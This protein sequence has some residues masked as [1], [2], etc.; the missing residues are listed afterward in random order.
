MAVARNKEERAANMREILQ[1]RTPPGMI[2]PRTME[3]FKSHVDGTVVTNQTELEAHNRRNDVIDAREW[4]NDSYCDTDAK[5][6]R[7][8]R[9]QGTSQKENR[10]RK[11]DFVE[12]VQKVEQ[13]YKPNIGQQ[14]ED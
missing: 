9:I 12:A 2:K 1:S 3:A 10:Q 8:A 7:E 13:G 11:E 6:E 4:G 5:K 14:E